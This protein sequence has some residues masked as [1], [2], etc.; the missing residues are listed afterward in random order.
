MSLHS[1]ASPADPVTPSPTPSIR[2]RRRL[3]TDPL[4]LTLSSGDHVDDTPSQ[5]SSSPLLHVETREWKHHKLAPGRY[6]YGTTK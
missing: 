6:L 5:P 3:T 2:A 4:R 1:Y